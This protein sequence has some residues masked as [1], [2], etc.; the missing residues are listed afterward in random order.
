LTQYFLNH[1]SYQ[2]LYL[3]TRTRQPIGQLRKTFRGLNIESNRIIDLHYPTNNT[4]AILV[5]NDYVEPFTKQMT[6]LKLDNFTD[7]DPID[8]PHIKNPLYQDRSPE[9]R[10]HQA[11]VIINARMNRI[12]TKIRQ[13]VRQSVAKYFVSQGWISLEDAAAAMTT[14]PAPSAQEAAEQMFSTSEAQQLSASPANAPAT[15][16]DTNV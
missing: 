2:Y 11:A 7:F 12:L 1:H 4:L 16:M 5:R 8:P 14:A 10:T 3:T 13:P 15:N 9:E 6:A